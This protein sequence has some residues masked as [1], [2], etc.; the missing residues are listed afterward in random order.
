MA[1]GRTTGLAG[2]ITALALLC[3][4]LCTLADFCNYTT[5]RTPYIGCF[6]HD[7]QP[8]SFNP[9]CTGSGATLVET[10]TYLFD[11]GQCSGLRNFSCEVKRGTTC[12]QGYAGDDCEDDINACASSPCDANAICIDK[13][14]P[15]LGDVSGRVCECKPGYSGSGETCSLIASDVTYLRN[16]MFTN[17]TYR[18]TTPGVYRLAETII[19]NPNSRDNGGDNFPREDQFE[20]QGGH[21]PRRAYS[22]GFFAAITV[23]VPHVSV[24][25]NGYA[26]I[27]SEE[28]ALMMRFYAA[29]ELANAPFHYDQGPHNFTNVSSL[30]AAHH[31][32]IYN[33]HIGRSSHHS[34]H[35]NGCTNIVVSNM[36]MNDF[37]VAAIS[38]NGGSNIVVSQSVVGPSRQDVPVKG[39]WSTG[40]FILP[41]VEQ[42]V[43]RCPSCDIVIDRTTHSGQD[44]L[45]ALVGLQNQT[46]MAVLCNNGKVP[47]V[48]DNFKAPATGKPDGSAIYGIVLHNYGSHTNGFQMERN[49]SV[50]LD[51]DGEVVGMVTEFDR[52]AWDRCTTQ[53]DAGNVNVRIEDVK[54]VDLDVTVN[55]VEA[56]S[57]LNY[58][59]TRRTELRTAQI[60]VVGAVYQYEINVDKDNGGV[61]MGNPISN[62]Q[63]FVTKH[64]D[65]VQDP[66]SHGVPCQRSTAPKGSQCM[67]SLGGNASALSTF[68]NTIRPSTLDWAAKGGLYPASDDF[69]ICGGDNMFHV[70]KGAFGVRID[71]AQN[72]VIKNVEIDTI[73]NSGRPVATICGKPT[74]RLHPMQTQ[75]WYTGTD[76]VGISF[77]ATLDVELVG[78]NTIRNVLSSSGNAYGLQVLH[79]SDYVKGR[80]IVGEVQTLRGAQTYPEL[81]ATEIYNVRPNIKHHGGPPI[82][83]T[84]HIDS[85]ACIP[86][87]NMEMYMDEG[88]MS[89]MDDDNDIADP[90]TMTCRVVVDLETARVNPVRSPL[91]PPSDY[92]RI[93]PVSVNISD[94]SSGGSDDGGSVS[95][96]TFIAVFVVVFFILLGL[97][98]FMVYKVKTLQPGSVTKPGSMFYGNSAYAEDN[99]NIVQS[100]A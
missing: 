1:G 21:Y 73:I 13:A 57:T 3:A 78:R 34:I 39:V 72:I 23:E 82:A 27:Q 37:E 29:I 100:T 46:M 9:P 62:A 55:E 89:M 24:D 2:A 28:H 31:V 58:D 14:P 90:H 85:Y 38:I 51:Q 30:N 67:R 59:K 52:N 35:G 18:I 33:G 43:K 75:Q 93:C 7:K 80:A 76:S 68:L 11:G 56:L 22:L 53:I 99:A 41:Y 63:L 36:T 95:R 87:D 83:E 44:I 88:M 16:S 17:G 64:L 94:G 79:V 4:P 70:N 97:I 40:I 45:D 74:Q 54:I 47:D 20:D 5:T 48:V 25:M 42:I 61:F 8:S 26:I 66:H 32:H 12:C 77:S 49:E 84:M 19:F 91:A 96:G 65:V 15:A 60:D 98:V 6:T 86:G 50:C 71:G 10:G 92:T 81:S 69:V